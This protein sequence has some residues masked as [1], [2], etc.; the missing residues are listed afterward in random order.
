VVVEVSV[1]RRAPGFTLIEIV[2]SMGLMAGGLLAIAPMFTSSMKSNAS[3]DDFSRVNALA[4]QQLEQCLQYGFDDPRLGVPAGATF[5]ARNE[6]GVASTVTGQLYRNQIPVSETVGGVTRTIPF[7]LVYTVQNYTIDKLSAAGLPDPAVAVTD[8]NLNWQINNGGK[9]I[10][11]YAASKR[12]SVGGTSY[13][14]AGVLS[15]AATGK[16]VRLTAYK[17]P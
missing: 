12:K 15:S 4:R 6:A 10:T 16:Q 17:S 13:T 11:V 5:T 9:F 7:E 8:T 1:N 3:G 2:V 14:R